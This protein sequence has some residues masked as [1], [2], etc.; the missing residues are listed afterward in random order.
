MKTVED[1]EPRAR[2]LSLLALALL[3]YLV[4]LGRLGYWQGIRHRDL[5]AVARA[6][7]DDRLVLPAVRG[8]LLDR[9]GAPLVT[10][11]P[12]FSI[13]ASP[14]LIPT[15]DRAEVADRLGAVLGLVPADLLAKLSTTRK[16]V[17]LKRRVP[18]SVAH[19]VDA[20]AEPGIG[21]I[22]ESQR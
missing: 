22:A 13:F 21:K 14:D 5:A 9:Y 16:F 3:A 17:Y 2:V 19:Q 4:L 1:V 6:Q 11:T 15:V 12:V 20:L 10:N 18:A 7:H 8:R